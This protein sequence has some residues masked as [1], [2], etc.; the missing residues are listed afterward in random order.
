MII[1]SGSHATAEQAASSSPCPQNK[2]TSTAIE[3]PRTQELFESS[4]DHE[5]EDDATVADVILEHVE[6]AVVNFS[7]SLANAFTSKLRNACISVLKHTESSV[8]QETA[9]TFPYDDDARFLD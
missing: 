7:S 6:N 4:E 5:D 9:D 3:A 2:A 8:L 1:D